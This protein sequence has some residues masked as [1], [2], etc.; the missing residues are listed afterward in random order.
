MNDKILLWQ[1]AEWQVQAKAWIEEKVA[2]NNMKIVGDI[3]QPHIYHWS[4]VMKIPTDKGSVFF[5]ATDDVGK[6]EA[7]I[8]GSLFEWLPDRQLQILAVDE[9]KGWML[10]PDGG[11]RFREA[12]T[13]GG[14]PMETW[15]DVLRQY[16]ELQIELIPRA[17]ELF[18]LGVGDHRLETLPSLYDQALNETQWLLIDKKMA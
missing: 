2:A 7:S 13:E 12:I 18:S 3:E 15:K 8:V 9:E 11:Q 6:F 10:M 14:E 1:Q 16:A 5:K 4:T 17:R